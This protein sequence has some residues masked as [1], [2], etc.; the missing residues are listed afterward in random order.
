MTRKARLSCAL[1]ALVL[2]LAAAAPASAG[3]KAGPDGL[4]FSVE[5]L[6]W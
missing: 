6:L 2:A 1:L 4:K 5:I 3:S